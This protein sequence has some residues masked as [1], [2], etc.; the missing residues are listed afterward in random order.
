LKYYHI[1]PEKFTTPSDFIAHV[2]RIINAQRNRPL[3][4][5]NGLT[6]LE[7][8]HGHIPNKNSFKQDMVESRK[9]RIAVNRNGCGTCQS[10]SI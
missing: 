10:R 9:K 7:A 5:L 8:L 2:D 1:Y 6:P 3:A 4:V